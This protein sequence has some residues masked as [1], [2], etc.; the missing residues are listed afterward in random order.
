MASA[1]SGELPLTLGKTKYRLRTQVVYEK[2]SADAVKTSSYIVQYKQEG[3]LGQWVNIGERDT[4]NPNNWVFTE[5]G[6]NLGDNAEV[7]KALINTGPNS[8]TASLDNVTS[9]TLSKSAAITKEEAQSSL[10]VLKNVT[11]LVEASKQPDSTPNVISESLQN[12]ANTLANVKIKIGNAKVRK[13]YGDY[14]YPLDMKNNRQDR[15]IFTMRQ[16][17]GSTIN[18]NLGQ[19]TISRTKTEKGIIEG[20][21]T[22][23]IQPSISD[24]NSVDWQGNNLNAVGAYAAGAS[25]NLMKS[26]DLSENVGT[27]LGNISNELKS[28]AAYGDA[29]KIYLAQEAVGLQGL[30]SRASGAILN[31]NM[32]L[33]FNAP[34]LRP[35]TF[36]FRL[37]PRSEVEA[38]QVK[39]IIRFFKQGMSVK[40][41]DTHVFLKAPNVFDIKYQS[42]D[43]NGKP[44]DNHPSL[45]RIKTCALTGCDVN[46]TPDGTYM[47]FNDAERTMTSYEMSLRFTELDPV[48]DS[49]YSDEKGNTVSDTD[50][51]SGFNPDSSAIGINEIGF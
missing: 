26:K 38:T 3:P 1:T 48:Y 11:P 16:S 2:V 33:L 6:A 13:K 35:F 46:Y 43:Q 50:S 41:V 27:I 36:T 49:D 19:R 32:E 30:L 9:N 24:S 8:V 44:F 23:P 5:T 34:S 12:A 29:L 25:L 18:A 15:I 31:P 51:I 22:L 39:N 37:S 45:N 17:E 28:N 40:T 7:T 14:C 4:E 42:Y 47:T 10:S 21:V 20:S